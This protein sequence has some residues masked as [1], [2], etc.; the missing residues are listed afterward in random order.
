[1]KEEWR[2]GLVA[3]LA[4]STAQSLALLKDVETHRDD[5]AFLRDALSPDGNGARL[6]LAKIE[7]GLVRFARGEL[8]HQFFTEWHTAAMRLLDRLK[9]LYPQIA[10]LH[11]SW[12][13]QYGLYDLLGAVGLTYET[14]ES[15][16]DEIRHKIAVLKQLYRKNSD[17]FGELCAEAFLA[18]RQVRV[19]EKA[20][21]KGE[22]LRRESPENIRMYRIIGE[23]Y[24]RA[25]RKGRP[26]SYLA[27]VTSMM[28]PGATY[29]ADLAGK[30]ARTW[31]NKTSSYCKNLL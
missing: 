27:L 26:I 8:P 12:N 13:A 17:A 18:A 22:S 9:E 4:E 24:Q 10:T 25:K 30:K 6:I 31:A 14:N 28:R 3:A 1:M 7:T 16:W 15:Y 20:K 29:A 5:Y 11:H 23:H 21:E 2:R 19:G